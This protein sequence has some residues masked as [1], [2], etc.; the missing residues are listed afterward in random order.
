M[1]SWQQWVK[2]PFLS[3]LPSAFSLFKGF[4]YC[5]WYMWWFFDKFEDWFVSLVQWD[6]QGLWCIECHWYQPTDKLLEDLLLPLS[7]FVYI[8][9]CSN[10]SRICNNCCCGQIQFLFISSHPSLYCFTPFLHE[11]HQWLSEK[12]KWNICHDFNL[13]EKHWPI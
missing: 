12:C 11:E 10:Q 6:V 9:T 8:N 4:I 2:W 7:F 3:L 5:F 1:H 13:D